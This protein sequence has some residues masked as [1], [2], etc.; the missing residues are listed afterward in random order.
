MSNNKIYWKGPEEL[1]KDP[2]Y[3]KTVANEFAEDLPMEEFLGDKQAMANSSTSRR[4]F[5]KFAG[6]SLAAA[7]LAACESPVVKTIP[8]VTKPENVT[9]GVAS[10]YAT[11]YYDGQLYGSILVK[12]REGRPIYIKGNK[13]HGIAGGALHPRITASV[14]PLYDGARLQSATAKGKA[15]SWT[16][17]D[18]AVSKEL[19]DV[20]NGGGKVYVLTNTII[21]PSTQDAIMRFTG[22]L[23]GKH[24]EPVGQ[25]MSMD[26]TTTGKPVV[27]ARAEAEPNPAPVADEKIKWVQYDAI[28]YN[29]IR[30]SHQ[31]SFGPADNAT[32]TSH[33]IIPDYDFSKAKVVVGVNADF[34]GNWMLPNQ[35]AV[36]YR[37]NRQAENEWM[38]KHFQF[39]TTLSLTGSNADVRVAIKP[40]EEGQV[41]AALYQHVTGKSTAKVSDAIMK[42]TKAAGEMLKAQ[43]GKGET[44]VVAGAND[45]N[46]QTLVNALNFELGN[47]NNTINVNNPI[48]MFMGKDAEVEKLFNE[49]SSNDAIL[50]YG[51]NPAYSLPKSLGAGAK[52]KSAKLSISFSGYADETASVCTYVAP[53]HH[54]LEAWND[55]HPK[56]NHYAIQ[57]PLIRPL[58]KTAAWQETLL[59]WA[60]LAQRVKDSTVFV[61]F[62]KGNWKK[63]GYEMMGLNAKF[64]TFTDYWNNCLHNSA[65]TVDI[66]AKFESLTWTGNAGA[67]GSGIDAWKGSEWEAIYYQK[68]GLGDGQ[69]ANNPWLQELPDPISRVTW[70]NYVTMN[71][72]DMQAKGFNMLIAQNYP[73]TKLK[74][75]LGKE[76]LELPVYPSPGQ[77]KNT[78]GIALGYGRGANGENIGRSAFQTKEYGDYETDA[79]GKNLAIGGNAFAA[80]SFN[81]GYITYAT[82]A[83]VSIADTGETYALASTQTSHTLM[84]RDSILRETTWSI[85]KAGN[86]DAYNEEH[87]VSYYDQGEKSVKDI[88][89][90][91]KHPIEHV[92]H[93][94]VMTID[95]NS[96]IGCGNCI[97]SCHS[98]NNVPVVGKDEVRRSRD[99][100][101]LRIDRYY[102]S[103]THK[104]DMEGNG[105]ISTYGKMEIPAANPQVLFQPMLCHHCN[106]APCE[107]VCPVLATTHSKEGLNQMTYN[108]CIGT[109]YC[110]NN[111]PYKVRRFNWFNYQDYKKFKHVNPAA[112]DTARWVL[113]PDVTVRSRGVME[114]CSFCV[115]RIQGGKLEAKKAG[116]KL[117]DGDVVT[118]CQE[119]CPTDAIKFGD[120]NDTTSLVRK[121]SQTERAYMAL[122]EVGIEPN[123]YYQVK[124]RN[125][126]ETMLVPKKKEHGHHEGHGEEKKEEKHA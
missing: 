92:G 22:K 88:D 119:A 82:L 40:S 61:D 28:S 90:W 96:C 23:Q 18:E 36:G 29:A 54:Y 42:N 68:I 102:S 51:C 107:T 78:I 50:I 60:G 122:E 112:D 14:L 120:W 33:W 69:Q 57:Q 34:L 101:W 84:E 108:R 13:Q 104:S 41:I 32:D 30:D 115:Q 44:L 103:D 74:V 123:V 79:K 76:T 106:H 83:G 75:T 70:D 81:G 121:E 116:R 63:Y 73:A 56:A 19:A 100:H 109:R 9:P 17:L 117:V 124:V 62:I 80:T 15:I 45:V 66:P 91:A 58:Y 26:S 2:N 10:W 21:S 6:F 5:L 94:W 98:E 64:P 25:P 113:N 11:S 47:Y 114:K 20:V 24:V 86:K 38:S 48:N 59:V 95:L 85:Y 39:E 31:K 89:L 110:A 55:C 111:C 43:M 1:T 77:A 3:M 105:V 8:Y 71:P 126:E 4:D 125:V 87:K 118:A 49:L 52:I 67:A 46:V 93:R 72:A 35:N 16:K 65:N 37:Q 12:S 99:M 53:D 7:T 27:A 97:I